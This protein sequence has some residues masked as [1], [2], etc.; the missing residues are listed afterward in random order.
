MPLIHRRACAKVTL[1]IKAKVYSNPN[2]EN[3]FEEAFFNQ[4]IE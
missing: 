2:L 4:E 1:Q 3:S